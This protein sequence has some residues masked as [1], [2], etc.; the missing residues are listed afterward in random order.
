MYYFLLFFGVIAFLSLVAWR[1]PSP[2]FVL[3][4][5]VGTPGQGTPVVD[6]A[7]GFVARLLKGERKL[8]APCLTPI[9]CVQEGRCAGHCGRR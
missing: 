8:D 7:G 9:D 1:S 4:R 3:A 6:A 5:Q 2:G